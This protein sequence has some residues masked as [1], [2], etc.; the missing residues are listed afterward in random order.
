PANVGRRI[1][2]LLRLCLEKD[3]RKRRRDAADMRIDIEQAL[4]EPLESATL[5]AREDIHAGRGL[6]SHV[7]HLPDTLEWI[8]RRGVHDPVVCG[9]EEQHNKCCDEDYASQHEITSAL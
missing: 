2:E 4:S 3:V 1:R 6:A 8:V 5:P 9:K 7:H